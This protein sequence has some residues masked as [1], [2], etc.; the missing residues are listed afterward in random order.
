M[1]VFVTNTG[2]ALQDFSIT[3][4]DK[5]FHFADLSTGE[6][7]QKIADL[8]E[9]TSSQGIGNVG[10]ST[11]TS[12][13]GAG[14]VLNIH[15]DT[16]LPTN[17]FIEFQ[18]RFASDSCPTCGLPSF[19]TALFNY[20]HDGT[21]MGTTPATLTATTTDGSTSSDSWTRPGFSGYTNGYGTPGSD[22]S[23][24]FTPG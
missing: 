14:D 16:P 24:T 8:I 23:D 1:E 21:T 15:F 10:F 22:N 11:P 9:T 13:A 17:D 20:C 5:D 6:P 18:V 4:G 7:P 2:P 3:L 19:E 12:G